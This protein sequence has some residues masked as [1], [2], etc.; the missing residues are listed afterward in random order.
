MRTFTWD[1]KLEMFVKWKYGMIG[2]TGSDAMPTVVSPDIY[3]QRF[4]DAMS[5]Y[6]LVSPDRWHSSTS[7]QAAQIHL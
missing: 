3:Q 4:C 5:R 6:F 7:Q 1:K 2:R